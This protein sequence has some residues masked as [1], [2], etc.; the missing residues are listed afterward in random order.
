MHGLIYSASVKTI[1]VIRL[2]NYKALLAEAGARLEADLRRT[3]TDAELARELGISGAYVSQLKN[4]KRAKIQDKAARGMESKQGKDVGWMDNDHSL[5]P[6]ETISPERYTSL[7]DRYKGMAEQEVRHLLEEWES[8]GGG[9]GGGNQ[10]MP[11][12][13]RARR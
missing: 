13:T 11:P 3:P 2:Q 4:E 10:D 12:E 1:D 6:F 8:K 7:P 5:W 9:L